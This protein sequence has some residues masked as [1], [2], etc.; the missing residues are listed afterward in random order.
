MP[1]ILNNLE[2]DLEQAAQAAIV[3]TYSPK[4]FDSKLTGKGGSS[5][6]LLSVRNNPPSVPA[7]RVTEDMYCNVRKKSVNHNGNTTVYQFPV[8]PI[9]PE[10]WDVMEKIKYP[11]PAEM[12]EIGQ[13]TITKGKT[14]VTVKLYAKL[15]VTA[16]TLDETIQ[17]NMYTGM[18][19]KDTTF[20]PAYQLML[21]AISDPNDPY[22]TQQ[23]LYRFDPRYKQTNMYAFSFTNNPISDWNDNISKR[24]VNQNFTV[25]HKAF[26]Q[27][28]M[29][30][31]IFESASEQSEIWQETIDTLIETFCDNV[32]IHQKSQSN[33]ANT[34]KEKMSEQVRYIMNYNIPLELYRNIYNQI[35]TTFPAADAKEICKQNLN[36]L[37]S[38]TLNNLDANK[39]QL[40][41]FQTPNPA[42]QLPASVQRLSKEQMSAV[43][44]TD[45]LILVQAGAGT[46]KSTLILGRIDYL[47]ACGIKAEDITILSFTNAAADHITEKNPNVHSM[48]IARMIHE[49]YTTN[50]KDHELSSLETLINSLEIYFP[51]AMQQYNST[52]YNFAKRLKAMVKNDTNNFTEMNNFIENNYDAVMGI[53]DTIRQTSL[54]LEIIIC[55]Q[56]IDTL[57][58][59]ASIQSKFLIIDEVQDNSI[60]EF[61]YTLKYIDKHKESMFIVGDC[62]Q[63]LYE[64]RASNPRALNIL[65]GSGTFSTFQ[66]NINYRSNQEILD[67]ANVLLQNIEA[68][69]YANIQLKANSR[70]QITE[71]SFLEKVHFDYCRLNK[72]SD[73][74]DALPSIFARDIRPYIQKCLA[75]G[76]QVAVLAFTRRDIA[77]IKTILTNQ[78]PNINPD[79]DIVSLVPDKMFNMTIMSKFICKY[80][81]QIQFAPTN[82]I[83]SV[84]NHEIMQKLQ[85]LT[86]NHQKAA[87]IVQDLLT[88]WKTKEGHT[89]N[90]WYNQFTNG[91]ITQD[92][93]LTYVKENMLQFEISTNAIKQ[94]LLSAK[95]Q[96]SKQSANISNAKFLLSTIHS[97]KGLEFDNVIVLYRNENNMDEDKKRMYY[98]AFT[99]AMKSEFILA[100]DTMISPQIQMDYLTVLEKLHA[101]SPAPNS[102]LNRPTGRTIK[103]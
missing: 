98:V 64:F 80:W 18:T 61:V 87:P 28:M 6:G 89:I 27:Y 65:E 42:I 77:A 3:K 24:L 26:M 72:I 78:F 43:T 74:H 5:P 68:N 33:N 96:K 31:E 103:I 85:Y 66:L 63:T 70:A 56:S 54:E 32:K 102:P 4:F 20:I 69:Q 19:K 1:I 91:Q 16:F 2:N 35:T 11:D 95:N 97:A 75:N 58:E 92:Q 49:I 73:F 51:V 71:Q 40:Q 21:Y 53:L 62:S 86:Y 29:D 60:F 55:Y 7:A 8:N 46:G 101:T 38:D 13:A 39:P 17:T 94:S 79:T 93:F 12:T 36:L 25:N 100:Y 34:L 99:R 44:S 84:I 41:T 59:P 14:P 45:P 48:T 47:I 52:E 81:N 15:N 88:K 67:M 76:E 50:F 10:C 90:I 57:V 23:E 9:S 22:C 30:Y 83:M 82:N 37:L